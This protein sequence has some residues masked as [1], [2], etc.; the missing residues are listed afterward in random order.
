MVPH[1]KRQSF[2]PTA[3]PDQFARCQRSDL[4]TTVTR[5]ARLLRRT[6]DFG[7]VAVDRCD[8]GS[9]RR[10]GTGDDRSTRGIIAKRTIR[11]GPS[12]ILVALH[13]S[14]FAKIICRQK[15]NLGIHFD[16]RQPVGTGLLKLEF[17]IGYPT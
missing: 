6:L 17:D 15:D 5:V 2:R 14:E 4:L 8:Y 16:R 9:P 7:G 12:H 3:Q 11:P 10:H 1:A 13:S